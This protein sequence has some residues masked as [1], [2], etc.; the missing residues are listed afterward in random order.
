MRDRAPRRLIACAVVCILGITSLS[1]GM[2]SPVAAT[3]PPDMTAAVAG[4]WQGAL[5]LSLYP[6]PGGGTCNGSFTGSLVGTATGVDGAGHPFVVV[7]PDPT[8]LL[9]A[10]NLSA[11]FAYNEACPLGT[12]GNALGSFTLS[13]G[14]VDDNGV[15]SH[16]G[17]VTG[18]FGWLRLGTAVVVQM[19]GGTFTGG[20]QTLATEQTLGIGVG[21][22]V[23]TSVPSTC[24][25]LQPLT[26]EVAGT[27][28]IQ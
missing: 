2:A 14:L 21:A 9:P 7:W 19:T 5:T 12:G 28:G 1:V 18:A 15:V 11:T 23:P 25:N 13:G 17:S 26:A 4:T 16:D 27:A 10:P 8:S 22:F 20:G 24:A 6:C 3:S